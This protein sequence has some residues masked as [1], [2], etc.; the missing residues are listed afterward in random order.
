MIPKLDFC[1]DCRCLID[2]ALESVGDRL[3]ILVTQMVE[4]P[5][6]LYPVPL[7]EPCRKLVQQYDPDVD[8]FTI[9]TEEAIWQD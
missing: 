3:F 1:P 8:G 7:C 6:G 2:A 9:T 4:I 5:I